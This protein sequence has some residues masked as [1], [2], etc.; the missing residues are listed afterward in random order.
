MKH[1]QLVIALAWLAGPAAFA[2]AQKP[3]VNADAIYHGGDIVTMDDKNPTA[4]AIAVKDGKIVAVG[5]KDAVLKLKGDGT[6]V[7]DLGGKTML[8]GFI[9]GHSHFINWLLVSR[10]ANCFSPPAGPANSIADIIAELKDLQE[11][12]KIP[13]GDDKFIIGYG[14]DSNVLAEQREMTAEDLDAD[15]PDNPVMVQH[16]SLHGAVF[17]SMA[18]KKFKIT[19]DTPTP[20]GGVILRKPG[21]NEPAGLVM[22]TAYLQRSCQSQHAEAR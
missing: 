13:E 7:I 21:S 3:A 6:K 17:N 9:D 8:P 14:Y 16:V 15:F 4:E 1:L 19:A 5:K 11:K 18:L 10:Q 12:Q 2:H 22:E 20:K